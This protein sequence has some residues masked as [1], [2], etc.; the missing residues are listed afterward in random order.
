MVLGR[1]IYVFIKLLPSIMA[2][3]KD[4]VLWISDD[5]KDVDEERFKR[6][7]RRILTPA[8]H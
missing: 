7:A 5:K 1:T 8:S 4:R 6:H 2:L 3:R